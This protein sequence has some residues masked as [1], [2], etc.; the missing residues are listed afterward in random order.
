MSEP[1]DVDTP[2]RNRRV[3][4]LGGTFDPPH[5]GHLALALYAQEHVGLDQI[6]FIPS[7]VPPHKMQKTSTPAALRWEMTCAAVNP[8]S[9]RLVVSDVEL[10]R[11]GPSY[12]YQTVQRIRTMLGNEAELFW[13][14]GRDNIAEIPLW[15]EPERI[16]EEATV[17]A[18]GRPGVPLPDDIP[19]WLARRLIV[20]QG[21]DL[22]VSSTAIREHASR[23]IINPEWVPGPVSEIIRREGLYG[24]PRT[25]PL[26]C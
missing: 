11:P 12:T 7:A 2:S 23:G 14:I 8:Y 22:P 17:I 10:K 21:P 4:L 9:P 6:W 18:G 3:G 1:N 20:L 19:G 15:M 16:V 13:I 24:Y 26:P 25:A 5:N